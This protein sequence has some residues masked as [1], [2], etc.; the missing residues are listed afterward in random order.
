ME[1]FENFI[2]RFFSFLAGPILGT[3]LGFLTSIVLTW[4]VSPNDF[5]VFSMFSL[6][7]QIFSIVALLGIDQYFMREFHGSTDKSHLLWNCVL[8]NLIFSIVIS[9]FIL[10]FTKPLSRLLFGNVYI[11][12]IIILVLVV[13]LLMLY[14]Y[15]NLLIIMSEKGLTYS[16]LQVI[17]KLSNLLFTVLIFFF[18]GRKF[19]ALPISQ[20][21]SIFVMF[22]FVYR[23]TSNF[24][25]R[26]YVDFSIMKDS[27]KYALPL[28][29]GTLLAWLLTSMDRIAL[30]TYT[31]FNEIAIYSV[32]FRIANIFGIFQGAFSNFWIPTSLRWYKNKVEITKFEKV[33]QSLGTILLVLFT[34]LLAFRNQIFL[35][36]PSFY[37]PAITM[38]PFLVLEP[39]L[40]TLVQTTHIGI[41][42]SK[43]T[44]YYTLGMGLAALLN[45]FG[46]ILLV[47]LYKGVGA[48]ISTG[49]SY[50]AYFWFLTV[51]SRKLWEKFEI[52]KL[53]FITVTMVLLAL[54]G[55]FITNTIYWIPSIVIMLF[56]TRNEIF[57][58]LSVI[59]LKKLP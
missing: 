47:P 52:R 16:F 39:V 31:D 20:L 42:F 40:N 26:T 1:S 2:K 51:W 50:F 25:K 48:S 9:I 28:F 38:L 57:R 36:F 8:V 53:L 49:L 10:L 33:M 22:S 43:K 18:L 30:R 34:V 6:A 35:I 44:A 58:M 14:R 17:E 21:V 54:L 27:M 56:I 59:K 5:G 13:P 32:A 41:N 37:R 23:L 11:S 15:G 29:P 45:F 46:N 3:V 55:L 24:W 7:V 12:V 19:I 4:L